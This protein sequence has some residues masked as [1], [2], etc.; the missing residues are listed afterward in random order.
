MDIAGVEEWVAGYRAA[1]DSN[2]P[3]EIDRLFSDEGLYFTS[4]HREPWRGRDQIVAGWIG[5]KDEP[6]S[7]DFRHEV[8]GVYGQ[9]GFVR[10]WTR[11]FDP[12]K[13]YSNLW[14]IKFNPRG[15][16]EEFTEWWMRA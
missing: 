1:W 8:L 6:G 9:V 15:E 14:V 12:P 2:N 5:R 11:Y 3:Q 7:Y 4:P 16:C 10:G 13:E